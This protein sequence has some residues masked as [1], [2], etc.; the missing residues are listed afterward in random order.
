[1]A[2]QKGKRINSIE[3]MLKH[4]LII[5]DAGGYKKTYHKGWFGSWQ[6]RYAQQVIKYGWIYEV[7]EG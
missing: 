5:F 1:M 7:K 6:I 3:E 4:E 2:K